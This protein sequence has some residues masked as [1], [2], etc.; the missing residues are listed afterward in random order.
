MNNVL[1]RDL[2]DT[3]LYE[4]GEKVDYNFKRV[5]SKDPRVWS[6]F[7]RGATLGVFQLEK[8]LG[9]DWSKKV[10]PTNIEELAAL[11]SILRPGCLEC[12]SGDTR[13]ARRQYFDNRCNEYRYEY[14]SLKDLYE[15]WLLFETNKWKGDR[16]FNIISLNEKTNE[17]FVNKINFIQKTGIKMVFEIKVKTRMN[18]YKGKRRFYKIKAT[19]GHKF[20]TLNGWKELKDI[21]NGE[22]ICVI[23]HHL[24]KINRCDKIHNDGLK[25]FR[26]RAFCTYKHECLF[27]DWKEGSLDVNHID[28]NR[29]SN[30]NPENL[31]FLC[32]NHHRIYSEGNIS[33]ELVQEK[34]KQKRL[35]NNDYV[36]WVMFEEAVPL[37]ETEV[38]DI[39]VDG[40]NHNY[41]AGDFI[42][43]NSGMAE[44]YAKRKNEEEKVEYFHPALEPILKK[45]YGLLIYQEQAMKIATELAGFTDTEADTLR[46]GIGKKLPEVIAK[47][48]IEFVEKADKKG[49]VTKKEAEEIFSWIEK[50]QRYGF[51]KSHAISYAKIAYLTAYQKVH[52]PT[53][54]YCAWLTFSCEK[55]DPKEEVAN[56]VNDAKFNGIQILTPDIRQKNR[57]FKIVGE[58]TIS[59]GLSHIRGIGDSSSDK[60]IEFSDKIDTFNDLIRYTP[61]LKRHVVESLIKSGACDFF[62]IP[63]IQM[64]RCIHSVFGRTE[65]ESEEQ[66]P[67]VKKLTPNEYKCFIDNIDKIGVIASIEKI[68]LDEICV[69]KRI[70][71]ISA[72]VAYLQQESD[73]TNRQKSIWEKLYLGLNLTC[74]AADDIEKTEKNVKTCREVHKSFP[75]TDVI[76][77]CVVDKVEIKK[78]GE[79]SKNPGSEYC[80]LTISDNTGS[81]GGVVAW[82]E[83][84][85]EIKEEIHEDCVCVIYARKDS[86]KGR[87]QII[88][89]KLEVLDK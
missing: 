43:H 73:D 19:S 21:Q 18:N 77:H 63:R 20:L 41:I 78:T 60:I 57:D 32:P 7:A 82:P 16:K 5:N 51:N 42:V 54:F 53:E 35:P 86:W 31:C 34:N 26:D 12:L 39:S 74:S 84:Y 4:I 61:K 79:K 11:V 48:K 23:N 46:K 59:F 88:V 38:Y 76:M 14:S 52:F 72:K 62:K 69:K 83:Q 28:G 81:L 68:S 56:L 2:S 44:S 80:Y 1:D 71:T 49:I 65:K 10:K 37:Y 87:D 29:Y 47:V 64:L 45:T 85:E 75:K 36:R 3:E 55:P 70:P 40:P 17:T 30:N 58:K 15:E 22:Y 24:G 89:K 27:C 6:L 66:R 13:I 50:F 33:K 25:T 8:Q 67:E 9:M